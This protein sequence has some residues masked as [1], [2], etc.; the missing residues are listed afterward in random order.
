MSNKVLMIGTG[1]IGRFYGS[2][3]AIAA[4]NVAVDCYSGYDIK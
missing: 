4:A 2:L 1:A 3:L